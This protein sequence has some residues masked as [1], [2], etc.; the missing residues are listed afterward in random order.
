MCKPI[1]TPIDPNHKLGK[2]EEDTAINREMY[3]H[4][5]GRLIYFSHTRSDI[6]HVVN[7]INQFIHNPK[8]VHAQPSA[9]VP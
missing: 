3:Q 8:E 5:V 1:S 6:A 4:L 2:I 7:V 9:I